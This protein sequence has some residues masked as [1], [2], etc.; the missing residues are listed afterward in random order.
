MYKIIGADQKEYGPI[1][2][3]QLRQWIL[4]G[5]ANAQTRAQAEG[6]AEW[7]VLS[8][9]PELADAL[10]AKNPPAGGA[11]PPIG[12]AAPLLSPEVSTSAARLDIA[13]LFQRSWTLVKNHF[14]L[15]VG[16]MALLIVIQI[17]VGSIPRLGPIAGAVLLG[18]LWAGIY[19]LLLK[20]IRGQSAALSDV[21]VGFTDGATFVQL[22]LLGVVIQ[23]LS[24]V[25]LL[26]CLAPGIYLIVAWVFAWPLAIDRRMDFWPAMELSRKTVHKQWWQFFGLFLAY[27]LAIV[28]GALACG[29]GV[30]IT[31]AVATGAIA[32]AYED[33]FSKPPSSV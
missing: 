29:V 4:E 28:V 21:F 24:L 27:L 20:L 25:G 11:A 17:A 2:L 3:D 12:A 10:A 33:I 19:L 6:T 32:Y 1:T 9:F 15:V 26:L 31:A 5:R 14:G 18:P 16:A 13:N 23:I 7:K 8:D 30:F 22:M